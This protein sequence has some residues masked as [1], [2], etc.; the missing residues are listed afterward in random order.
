MPVAPQTTDKQQL[1]LKVQYFTAANQSQSEAH[2]QQLEAVATAY[3]ELKRQ[4]HDMQQLAEE[5]A[6]RQIQALRQQLAREKAAHAATYKDYEAY[7]GRCQ[8]LEQQGG[9]LASNYDMVCR[10]LMQ[11]CKTEAVFRPAQGNAAVAG[12]GTFGVVTRGEAEEQVT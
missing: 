9:I 5:A 11:S 12:S 3:V 10:A 1:A 7:Q 4:T 2:R 8:L 6:A